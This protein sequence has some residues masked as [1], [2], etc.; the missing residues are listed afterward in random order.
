MNYSDDHDPKFP[1]ILKRGVRV[2]ERVPLGTVV[3]NFTNA[4]YTVTDDDCNSQPPLYD[5]SSE[6]GSFTVTNSAII[7]AKE[8]DYERQNLYKVTLKAMTSST[9]SEY[10][11]SSMMLMIYVD[12]VDDERPEFTSSIY[13]LHVMEGPVP[14]EAW[15][16]TEPPVLALDGDRG[17][18]TTLNYSFVDPLPTGLKMKINLTT[19]QLRVFDALDRETNSSFMV[20]VKAAQTDNDLMTATST[21][22]IVVDDR[23]DNRPVLTSQTTATVQ[24]DARP[25]TTVL[26]LTATD[27]DEGINS[28][29]D[30]VMASD[31]LAAFNLSYD[32]V[33][34]KTWLVVSD[35]KALRGKE[36]GHV[37]VYLVERSPPDGGAPC[38]N[39][40]TC[41][42]DITVTIADVNMN[43]PVFTQQAYSFSVQGDPQV[44]GQVN[45]AD[46]DRGDNAR[47]SYQLLSSAVGDCRM[48]SINE[49][50]GEITLTSKVASLTTCYMMVT[51][52]D[53]PHD[54]SLQRCTSVPVSVILSPPAN[55]TASS[56]KDV[57]IPENVPVGTIVTDLPKTNLKTNAT[58]FKIVEDILYT[59]ADR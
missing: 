47:I 8:L 51:A 32:D 6:T 48:M 19:G 33:T 35:S 57:T 54:V 21:I 10:R 38:D 27:Q 13:T 12:D 36:T 52:C 37:K 44:V 1:Q 24:E 43:S 34:Q 2:Q 14:S 56:T 20:V 49:T 45:A 18:N 3:L 5:V 31:D 30:Y 50:S 42:A 15:L 22:K 25:G 29:F 26:L 59:N 7:V 11:T 46:T 41:V 16:T 23:N 9:G 28:Q 40:T 53:N 39:V 4:N 17:I 58:D 55:T